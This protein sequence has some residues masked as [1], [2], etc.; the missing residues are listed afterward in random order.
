MDSKQN[1]CVYFNDNQ[2]GHFKDKCPLLK[3]ASKMQAPTHAKLRITDGR[4]GKAEAPRDK[5][6]AFQL[7]IEEAKEGPNVVFNTFV[8][9]SMSTLVLFDSRTSHSFISLKFSKGF[10]N[11]IGDL[12]HPLRVE[13]AEDRIVK[14]PKVYYSCTLRIYNDSFRIHL[15]PIHMQ[16]MSVIVG[17]D[18][19]NQFEAL[20]DIR[21]KVV[22][23]RTPS[24][25]ELTIRGEGSKSGSRFCST[26]S[27]RK[28]L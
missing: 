21:R 7:T 8:V 9:N 16:G 19:L 24:S 13:I 1:M 20:I 17:V 25:G 28:Y 27:D 10:S 23:V 15:I 18:W 5:G 12:D 11:T 26:P 4:Q 3:K 14:A 6:R 22:R 2:L